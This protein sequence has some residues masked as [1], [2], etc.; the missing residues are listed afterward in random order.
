MKYL[1]SDEDIAVFPTDAIDSGG[2]EVFQL[3]LGMAARAKGISDIAEAAGLGRES[4]YKSMHP[5]AT[6]RFD[7]VRRVLAALGR[8][9]TLATF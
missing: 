5:D 7:T 9:I 6:P 1:D 3:A 4:L 8:R 2:A